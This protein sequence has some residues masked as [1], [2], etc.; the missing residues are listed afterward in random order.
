MSEW[1]R[2]LSLGVVSALMGFALAEVSVRLV[3]TDF[4]ECDSELGWRFSPG[5]Q[6]IRFSRDLEFAHRVTIN[7]FG[8]RDLER[9]DSRE[10]DNLRILLLGDSFVAGM[11]VPLEVTMGQVLER[12]LGN[13]LEVPVEVLN[14][15][16][17][18]YGTGQQILQYSRDLKRFKA[19]IVILGFYPMNDLR[20]NLLEF[21][22]QK[23]GLAV[24]CGRPYFGD[25]LK[26]TVTPTAAWKASGDM[27]ADKID[28]W[29]RDWSHLY[30]LLRPFP[31]P[32][33]TGDFGFRESL[34]LRMAEPI[35]E[36]WGRTE[37][38]IV[39]LRDT[40]ESDGAIF[41]LLFIPDKSDVNAALDRLMFPEVDAPQP[42]VAEQ[43]VSLAQRNSIPLINLLPPFVDRTAEGQH[44]LYFDNDQHWQSEGHA[45]AAA[46]V[47]AWMIEH[48]VPVSV[49][50]Q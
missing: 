31:F 23:H 32:T 6:G 22:S 50:P 20:D 46:E 9:D 8:Y 13:S 33:E 40:V 15:G 12:S 3:V 7:S 10:A 28:R 17:D 38:L 21:D 43:V 36:A 49:G 47:A 18:G 44:K 2:R 30:Q 14:A 39:R 24:R 16:T 42:I 27:T 34:K 41:I 35:R 37:Q 25:D 4:Y 48:E 11:Q 5:Q 29:L 45:L 26:I 19:D 1:G